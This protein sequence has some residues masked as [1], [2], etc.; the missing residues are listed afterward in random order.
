MVSGNS[1]CWRKCPVRRDQIHLRSRRFRLIQMR[2]WH[3]Y[4]EVFLFQESTH[5]Y[6][7]GWKWANW[8]SGIQI[9]L[10]NSGATSDVAKCLYKRN[11]Q[12]AFWC[13]LILLLRPSWIYWESRSEVANPPCSAGFPCL[14]THSYVPFT[15]AEYWIKGLNW[16]DVCTWK[17]VR[18]T[19]YNL[20]Y[21][22]ANVLV[23]P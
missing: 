17:W 7:P 11:N 23:R 2:G 12:A 16:S 9:K 15:W 5:A 8:I 10:F 6:Y 22:H 20:Y 21:T 19:S 13:I 1:S 14:I 3:W 18:T 4:L